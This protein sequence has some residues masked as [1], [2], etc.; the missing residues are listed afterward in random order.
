MADKRSK[1][2]A[3]PEI[4]PTD[5]SVNAPV[6]LII[7]V[8]ASGAN[9][10]PAERFLGDLAPD[11]RMAVVLI[12]QHREALDEERF[13][14][15]LTEHREGGRS[16]RCLQGAIAEALERLDRIG[17]DILV[18]LDDEDRLLGL[19]PG[20]GAGGGCGLP[21]R[22]ERAQS[23]ALGARPSSA[24]RAW[25]PRLPDAG[26][27]GSAHALIRLQVEMSCEFRFKSR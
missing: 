12:F 18:V 19:R 10:S 15:V 9:S 22:A 14:Q 2:S 21:V 4:T 20:G 11:E 27:G 24:A 8:G 16:V 17:A 1:Q 25:A 7:A 13:S 6:D 3:Q 26:G 5:G 23:G